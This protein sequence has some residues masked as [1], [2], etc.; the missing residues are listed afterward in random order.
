MWD[1]NYFTYYDVDYHLVLP[2]TQVCIRKE[3]LFFGNKQ[4]W[5]RTCINKLEDYQVLD[6]YSFCRSIAIR[7][8]CALSGSVFLLRCA[9]MFITSLSVP[10]SHLECAPRVSNS[11]PCL[12]IC[13][14]DQSFKSFFF[15]NFRTVKF[16]WIGN[17]D[18]PDTL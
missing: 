4:T 9:T 15:P 12:V 3:N 10:G 7:R 1:N 17:I 8:F 16:I 11:H 14:N 5:E 6:D 13:N 2:Q 18:G